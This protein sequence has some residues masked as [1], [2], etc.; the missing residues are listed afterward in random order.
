[1]ESVYYNEFDPFAAAWLREL[2]KAGAIPKGDVDDRSITEVQP[3]DLEGYTQCHFFAGIGGWA[4]ALK[5]AGWGNKEVWTGSCPCQ[6]F[7]SA[8][9][10]KGLKDERHLWP[11][12][13]NLIQKCKPS[14]VFGEQVATAIGKGWLDLVFGDLERE[15]YT[16]GAVVFGAHSVGGPHI[17]QRLYW[18]GDS[19][20]SRSLSYQSSGENG[21]V[22][23]RS[24]ANG[25]SSGLADTSSKRLERAPRT[26]IPKQTKDE[27]NSG[28]NNRK[29]KQASSGSSDNCNAGRRGGAAL[30]EGQGFW[31]DWEWLSFRDS[32][33]RPIESGTFPLVDGV[34]NRV[35][36]LRG[37]GNALCVPV[38]QA[39]VE[40]YAETICEN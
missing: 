39:F 30:P 27:F 5:Q 6:P 21:R 31:K 7:S 24:S 32:K 26:G 25:N 38:A 40:A 23:G 19:E 17:R 14:V 37:Y 8:G 10:Q 34:P 9:K 1:M 18:L 35:G 33:R 3:K 36:R 20:Y 4:L 12:F 2:I 29:E 13:F 28:R 22:A 15:K 16:C 11:V